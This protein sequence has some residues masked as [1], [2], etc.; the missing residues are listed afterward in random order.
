M[1][2]SLQRIF[3]DMMAPDRAPE[4]A[5]PS[6]AL[7]VA[8]LLCEV[9]R[10]DYR[11]EEAELARLGEIL[12]ARFSLPEAEASALVRQAC[13]ETEAAVD[14]H[15]FLRRVR[16]ACAYPARVELVRAMWSLALVDGHKDPLEEHRIRRLAEL[17]HVRH[18]DF[19]RARIEVE[20]EG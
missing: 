3:Q 16:D 19:V 11:L 13:R 18:G 12:A 2:Q 9:I 17:L 14:H 5:E 10:A 15:R 7:A 20:G 6:L 1:I 4:K 8:V